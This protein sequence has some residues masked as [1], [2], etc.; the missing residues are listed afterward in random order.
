MNIFSRLYFLSLGYILG[1]HLQ[2]VES[3]VIE[4]VT[5]SFTFEISVFECD[6]DYAAF[7]VPPTYTEPGSK[8]RICIEPF[9]G[10]SLDNFELSLTNIN[11]GYVYQPVFFGTNGPAPDDDDVTTISSSGPIT[12][13][14]TRIVHGL[15]STTN[16]TIDILGM[17]HLT[18]LA[19]DEE[20]DFSSF[21]T[22]IKLI[23]LPDDESEPGCFLQLLKR[24][25]RMRL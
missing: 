11:T 17:A 10:I 20:S 23:G 13:V 18:L 15:F 8:I 2:S 1:L 14:S 3:Q 24:M 12:M 9:E 19:K 4:E 22:E 21:G 16:S 7:N 25:Q 6:S 5:V